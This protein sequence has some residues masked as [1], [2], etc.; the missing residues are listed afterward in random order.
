MRK[1]RKENLK[2]INIG[3][4]KNSKGDT[5]ELIMSK[6]E[7]MKRYAELLDPTLEPTFENM[8]YTDEMKNAIKNNLT[9]N[10]I[11]FVKANMKFLQDYYHRVAPVYEEMYGVRLPF[12]EF[13]TPIRRRGIE[14]DG[15][16][17]V[18]AFLGEQ[19]TRS[20]I[21]KGSL[22]KRINSRKPL[23]DV[24]MFSSM[25]QHIAEMEHFIAFA[26][27]TREL[28]ATFNNDEVRE[29]IRQNF[30]ESLLKYIDLHVNNIIRGGADNA[31][32]IAVL[33]WTRHAIVKMT[34]A[35]K[36]S[37]LF[38][39]ISSFVAFMDA[40]PVTEFAKG[41]AL[42]WK[43]PI[44]NSKMLMRNSEL[45][46]NRGEYMEQDYK[47]VAKS[48]V[49]DILTYNVKLGDRLGI[50]F[51]GY[52]VYNYALN[53]G[54]V[55]GAV[56]KSNM[57]NEEY[58]IYAFEKIT[59]Q[60]Q[61]S[62]DITER[63]AWQTG[64]SLSRF[65]TTYQTSQNQYFRKEWGAWRNLFAGRGK[66]S[67]NIKTIAVFHFVVPTVFQFIASGFDWDEDEMKRAWILG[68]FNGIFILN[69]MFEMAVRSATGEKDF[70]SEVILYDIGHKIADINR[71]IVSADKTDKQWEKFVRGSMVV[72]GFASGGVPIKTGYDMMSGIIDADA[73]RAFGYSKYTSEARSPEGKAKKYKAKAKKAK[74]A[75]DYDKYE[76]YKNKYYE[77]AKKLNK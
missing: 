5:V 2:E 4:F 38:K 50:L 49:W 32:R 27:I 42:F 16:S 71:Y 8:G 29:A 48:R 9:K 1:L 36:P 28:N 18:S 60:T 30:D 75:G 21:F 3:T 67:Q 70:S 19:S 61:Q 68:S 76:D 6:D 63:S 44:R 64:G 51:G 40:I 15:M 10:D 31:N 7:I 12:N 72:A 77:E 73:L 55:S 62:A 65:F 39:Q 35:I 56:R 33:D 53:G 57:T 26:E 20:S 66:K 23:K 46:R 14:Y 41:T 43:N 45:M 37:I 11:K 13:Y 59:E 69:D 54:K 52:A 25:E 17:N 34:L 74:K 47:E 58:A 24:G 22:N